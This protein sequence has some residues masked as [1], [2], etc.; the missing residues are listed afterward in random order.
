MAKLGKPLNLTNAQ[1]DE[2]A[3]IT[4]EDIERVNRRWQKVVPSAIKNLLVA[5]NEEQNQR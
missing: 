3:E 5:E 2:L 1:L 4:D